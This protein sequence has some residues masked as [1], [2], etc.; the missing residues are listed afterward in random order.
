MTSP[1]AHS[2]KELQRLRQGRG[3]HRVDIDAYVGPYVRELCGIHDSDGPAVIRDKI[4]HRLEE[5]IS[6][7]PEDLRLT[8]RT[9][10]GMNPEAQ[11]PF[12]SDR[13][14]WLAA[15]EQRE[16]R[17]II[18]RIDSAL[19]M[20]IQATAKEG[21]RRP[22]P[23]EDW[24]LRQFDAFLRM[25]G[26]TPVCHEVRKIVANK[27]GLDR[28][29]WSITLPE[30]ADGGPG[31]LD[32]EVLRGV[33]LTQRTKVSARRFLLELELPQPLSAGQTHDFA[34]EVKVPRGQAMRPTYVFWP[35]RRCEQF[36]L[37][38]RFDRESQP[39]T[40]WQVTKAFHRDTDELEPGP[41]RLTVDNIGEVRASFDNLERSHGY[42][43]QWRT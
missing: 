17:T 40:I 1:S 24:H 3:V 23:A 26:P 29:P 11:L 31:D 6:D 9:A 38:I 10:L 8:V 15:R 36:N 21:R 34:M 14:A 20:I 12:L 42:G 32:I 37:V 35:E 19:N 27:D 30:A 39:R 16:N 4:T 2:L 18:R 43:I 22:S 13:V 7:L 41:D 25:D 28:I 5:L 33:V